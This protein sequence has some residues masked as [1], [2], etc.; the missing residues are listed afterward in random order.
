MSQSI[1][2][3]VQAVFEHRHDYSRKDKYTMKDAKR[4]KESIEFA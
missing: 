2:K 4:R 3:K 1:I